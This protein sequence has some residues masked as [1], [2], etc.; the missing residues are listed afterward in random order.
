LS[1][2]SST[3]GR[4]NESA[5]LTESSQAQKVAKVNDPALTIKG[6]EKAARFLD[7]ESEQGIKERE[8]HETSRNFKEYAGESK[9]VRRL[10]LGG[11]KESRVLEDRG[12]GEKKV[13]TSDTSGQNG[14][15]RGGKVE[16]GSPS[17]QSTGRSEEN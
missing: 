6:G 8:D 4:G 10:A 11:E 7:L 14:Y 2:K 15:E 17:N 12:V 3:G 13:M 5:E 9:E 16:E 1:L